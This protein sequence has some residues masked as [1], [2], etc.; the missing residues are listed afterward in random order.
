MSMYKE[1]SKELLSF[2]IPFIFAHLIVCRDCFVLFLSA[3]V[4]SAR[5]Q[6]QDDIWDRVVLLSAAW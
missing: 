6:S 5:M 1:Q 2:C 3:P 4:V